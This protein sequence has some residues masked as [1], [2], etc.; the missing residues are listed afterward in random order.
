MAT[1]QFR[2]ATSKRGKAN[3]R[4]LGAKRFGGAVGGRAR[5]RRVRL[6]VTRGAAVGRSRPR[7]SACSAAQTPPAPAA[8]GDDGGL[9]ASA[10]APDAAAATGD[11]GGSG[12]GHLPLLPLAPAR[13]PTLR[14]SSRIRTTT[15]PRRPSTS[16]RLAF[17]CGASYSVQLIT[18]NEKWPQVV[19]STT[20][21]L[22][23]QTADATGSITFVRPQRRRER[24][25]SRCRSSTRRGPPSRRRCSTTATSGTATLAGPSRAPRRPIRPCSTCRRPGAGATPGPVSQVPADPPAVRPPT[26]RWGRSF[27]QRWG[28]AG[29]RRWHLPRVL[30]PGRPLRDRHGQRLADRAR[31]REPLR[32]SD[33]ARLPVQ[34]S[35]HGERQ[36]LL[37]PRRDRQRHRHHGRRQ[38]PVRHVDSVRPHR[39][40]TRLERG[41]DRQRTDRRDELPVHAPRGRPRRR[42]DLLPLRDLR[43]GVQLDVLG[44]R[45]RPRGHDDRRVDLHRPLEHD[46]H[47]G[48][49][50]LH[51]AD[52]HKQHPQRDA[53]IDEHG[54]RLPA[55]D[56]PVQPDANPPV[57]ALSQFSSAPT[58]STSSTAALTVPAGTALH[59]LV[60]GTDADVGDTVS[61]NF[62]GA[63]AGGSEHEPRPSLCPALRP[64]SRRSPGRRRLRTSAPTR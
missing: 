32:H 42:R 57:C 63:P 21:N 15:S 36:R 56:R 23:A 60:T 38:L 18:P 2:Q 59:F 24:Q 6:L 43:G 4:C 55:G 51:D 13:A 27:R 25:S 34:R 1:R 29:V 46:R 19:P 12:A 8:R 45:G 53:H 44:V 39:R 31:R 37:P 50:A 3:E 48:G 30:H 7:R 35:L 17:R 22:P 52:P 14:T 26:S 16:T 11:D 28:D 61:M 49:P 64:S 41:P 10:P 58:S 54:C 20:V 40:L 5:G 62:S 9:D 47:D 33:H